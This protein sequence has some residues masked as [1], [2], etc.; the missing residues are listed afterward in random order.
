[1]NR[2][3]GGLFAMKR[4]ETQIAHA[5]LFQI[6]MFANDSDNISLFLEG[7]SNVLTSVTKSHMCTL[8]RQ[9]YLIPESI[10]KN[11]N[12]DLPRYNIIIELYNHVTRKAVPSLLR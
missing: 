10:R 2:K 9:S 5:A 3:G 1:M 6:D 8:L 4:T 11:D 7:G 12:D